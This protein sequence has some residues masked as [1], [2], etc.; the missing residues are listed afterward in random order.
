MF[1]LSFLAKQLGVSIGSA[2]DVEELRFPD[3]SI[4]FDYSGNCYL[5]HGCSRNFDEINV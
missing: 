3:T 4:L 2:H 5:D 1:P